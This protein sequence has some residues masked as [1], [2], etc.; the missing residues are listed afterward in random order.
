L[1]FIKEYEVRRGMNCQEYYPELTNFIKKIENDNRTKSST[2]CFNFIIRA[3]MGSNKP[4]NKYAIMLAA[5]NK[6]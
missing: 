5:S 1:K 6:R 3:N 2:W 4:A